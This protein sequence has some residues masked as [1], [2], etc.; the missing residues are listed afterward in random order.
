MLVQ[1]FWE[2]FETNFRGQ[3]HAKFDP[4]LDDFK[5]RQRISP[6]RKRYLKLDK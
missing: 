1:N 2:I 3:K 6:E 4:I 5:V